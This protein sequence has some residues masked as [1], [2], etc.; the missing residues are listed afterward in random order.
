MVIGAMPCP[1]LPRNMV[2][3]VTLA[4]D[5]FLLACHPVTG[6]MRIELH[7]PGSGARWRAAARPR[8]ARSRGAGRFSC[9]GHRSRP[10][11]RPDPGCP[12][13]KDRRRGQGARAGLLGT[14]PRQGRPHGGPEPSRRGRGASRR[15]S[16]GARVHPGP[17]DAGGGRPNQAR[18]GGPSVRRGGPRSP[19]VAP[20][21][22]RSIACDRRRARTLHLPA[23]GQACGQAPNT[24]IAEGNWAEVAVKQAIDAVNA[25]VGI[26]RAPTPTTSSI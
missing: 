13:G 5:L 20:D 25:A 16:Q 14:P 21:R 10:G 26:G 7:L 4:E 1:E 24:E 19:T 3:M 22:R 9:R 11:R 23:S 12:S 18:P 8:A 15:R 17:P 2:H 6:R